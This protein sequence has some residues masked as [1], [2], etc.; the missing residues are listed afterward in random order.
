SGQHIIPEGFAHWQ[1]QH[2]LKHECFCGSLSGQPT[3]YWFMNEFMLGH[4]IACCH[5]SD[6]HCGFEHKSCHSEWLASITN[7]VSSQ[8]KCQVSYIL[9]PL[10]IQESPHPV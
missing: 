9:L 4:T 6:N 3:P 10:H 1:E 2:G 7:S 8:H 5:F